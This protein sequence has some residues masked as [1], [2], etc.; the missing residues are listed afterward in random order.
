MTTRINKKLLLFAVLLLASFF[1]NIALSQQRKSTDSELRITLDTDLVTFDAQLISRKTG[2]SVGD[3]SSNDFRLFE[4]GIKQEIAYFSKDKLPLSIILLIDKSGSVARITLDLQQK[5]AL[6]L[7][8]LK[9]DDEVALMF[10]SGMAS[11]WVD[12]TTDH[13]YIEEVLTYKKI[14]AGGARPAIADD[15]RYGTLI[16]DSIHQ[17]AEQFRKSA[18]PIGRRVM[19]VI[20]DNMPDSRSR[21]RYSEKEIVDR[22]Y[23]TGATVYGIE[24]DSHFIY[25]VNNHNPLLKLRKLA[26]DN[27]KNVNAF[28][29]KTGGVVLDGGKDKVGKQLVRLIKMLRSRYSVGYTPSNLQMDNKF[30]K[31]RLKVTPEIEKR[32]GGVVILTKQGYYARKRNAAAKSALEAT[33]PIRQD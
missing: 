22:L 16:A 6:V 9:P 30:R 26:V 21:T 24:V 17:A 4:D 33:P 27:G 12:F 1:L 3:L 28:A 31:I 11:L 29:D 8:G 25:T 5:G 20:T 15:G 32:E 18:N 13:Q 19:I 14:V 10:F 23:E 2:K 7:D